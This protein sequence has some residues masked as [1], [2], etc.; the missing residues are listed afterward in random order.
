VG[1]N[2]DGYTRIAW[3]RAMYNTTTSGPANY[4][5]WSWR[6][7]TDNTGATPLRYILPLHNSVI[8]SSLG[9]LQNQYGY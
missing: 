7:Y 5:L 3:T 9:V 8:S 2:P 1:S 6:G 4:V